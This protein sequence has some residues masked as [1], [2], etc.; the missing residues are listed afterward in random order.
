MNF[1]TSIIGYIWIN[2]LITVFSRSIQ[3]P[4]AKHD[5]NQC[6]VYLCKEHADM[7]TEYLKSG[8][9][10]DFGDF[11]RKSHIQM[12]ETQMDI[13]KDSSCGID[14]KPIDPISLMMIVSLSSC[15]SL[16][17]GILYAKYENEHMI[18][19]NDDEEEEQELVEKD[20]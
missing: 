17:I 4:V 7:A 13:V 2:S 6:A 15:V 19:M 18:T 14:D 3:D 20:K 12:I 11:I 5:S 8:C 9:E 1:K 16:F 10:G